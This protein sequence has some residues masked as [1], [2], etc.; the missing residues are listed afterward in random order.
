ML[1]TLTDR[2]SKVVKTMKGEA[3]IT[4][5][6]TQE[7]LRE[8]RLALLD[9]DVALPVVKQFVAQVREKAVGQEVVGSL[10][11][12]Q[13]L[14]GV[15]HRELVSLMAS[16]TPPP[17][18]GLNLASQPPAIVLMAGLQGA[19]KTTSVGKMAKWLHDRHKKKVLTVSCDVYRP[20][21][22]EQLQLVSGQAGVDFFPSTADQKPVDIAVAAVDWARRHFHDVLLIDTA[23][24]L[25]IDA[26]LMAEIAAIH[27]AVKPV[28]TLFTVDAM[29]GQDAVR[30]AEAFGQ[31][32]PLTG[33]VLTKVDGDARG[34]AVLSVRS[35]TGKPV[36]FVGTSEKIDGL[37]AF[38]PERFAQ[39]ILGMGDVLALV[40]QAQ[41]SID[42][43]SAEK[44]AAKLKSGARFD[45]E[46]FKMQIG[47]M[48]SM[49]GLS[50]LMDKLPAQFQQAAKGGDMS[51]A[52]KSIR[53][54]EGLINAMTPQE[55]R[56]PELLKAS[57]KRRVA[58]GAGVQVQELNRMLNQFEQMQTMMK[59]MQSGGMAKI[60]R[61]MGGM[62]GMA[63]MKGLGGM[64]G[65]FKR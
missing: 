15:V 49:G 51:A 65:G 52:D 8:I 46:D 55:R 37:E 19:G 13:A 42:L 62:G 3:R 7:M 63:G 9:A 36:R 10:T 24:R 58:A 57:R 50:S 28:E 60:M 38:D 18:T 56:N 40:E 22:I 25:A 48:K 2:L 53:R 30:T 41:K 16:E 11:P 31:A 26:E 39:R 47:Q 64:M 1:E 20:A 44:M 4:E 43:K 59:K 61:A 27:A 14:V 54:M 12:G 33:I 34:G 45:L 32:L 29:Q 5:S 21:A 35:I 17:V 23:G 6:N